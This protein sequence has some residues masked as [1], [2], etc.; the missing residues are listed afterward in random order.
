MNAAVVS[1][2]LADREAVLHALYEAAELEHNLMCTYL[3]AAFSLR[4]E[5]RRPGAG[6][7]GSNGA[8]ATVAVRHRDRRDGAPRSRVEHHVRARRQPALRP[9]Q[10]SRSIPATC[11]RAWS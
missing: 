9:R 8:L 2:R 5:R 3:Y 11:R 7:G 4:T 10:L 6:R 1:P